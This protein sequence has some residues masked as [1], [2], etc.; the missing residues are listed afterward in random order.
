MDTFSKATKDDDL[1]CELCEQLVQ[2][3]ADV[4][5]TNT[6]E[7]EFE[8]VLLGICGQTKSFKDEVYDNFIKC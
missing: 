3:L 1:P 5:V 8:Q 2:H 4:L 6:T 7:Q